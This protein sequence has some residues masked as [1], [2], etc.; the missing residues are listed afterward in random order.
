VRS[1]SAQ[2]HVSKVFA[3]LVE[4]LKVEIMVFL[5]SQEKEMLIASLSFLFLAMV[6]TAVYRAEYVKPQLHLPTW[7]LSRIKTGDLLLF[8]TSFEM[9]TDVMK[10]IVGCHY[11][12]VGIAFV[13]ATGRPFVFEVC[14][15]GRGNQLNALDKRLSQK[16]E[17]VV[18]RPLNRALDG[19]KFEQ[20]ALT[21]MGMPYSYN[22][23][24]IV[25]RSWLRPFMMLPTPN[26]DKRHCTEG[27]VCTQLVADMY[28]KMG[29]FDMSLH[30]C[31][32]NAMTPKDFSE[33]GDRMPLTARYYFKPS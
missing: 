27:R 12:H 10:L 24:P 16:N 8:N 30:D 18:V 29:V 5:Q 15:N 32:S 13:D 1:H 9:F 17:L 28:E 6:M 23:V 21:M 26:K 33:D 3:W 2:G 11:V 31:G 25:L 22:V 14:T 19:A 20:V 7:P 4:S